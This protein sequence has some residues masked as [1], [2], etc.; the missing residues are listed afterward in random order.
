MTRKYF[1]TDGARGVVGGAIIN[2]IWMEKLGWAVGSTIKAKCAEKPLILIGEDSRESGKSL[3]LALEKGL[4]SA[5]A[6]VLLLGV[7]STPAIAYLTKHLKADAALVISASHNPYTDNGIKVIGN[8][9]FKFPDEWELSIEKKMDEHTAS[10]E[11]KSDGQVK[12]F[13]NAVADYIAHCK[14]LFPTLLSQYKI[15]IDCA[16][17]ATSFTAPTLFCELGA[18]VTAIHANPN[19]KNIN[20]HCGA[21]NVTSL[22]EKVLSEKADCGIAFDGDGDRLMM[23]DQRGEVVDGDEILGIITLHDPSCKA[24][25]GTLM[26]NLGLE[27]ALASHHIQFERV[28]V[29]DR[30]VLEQLRK[31]GWHLG[32]E[33]SGHI[34]NLHYGTT[35]DGIITA[36]QVLRIMHDT[37]NSLHVL[38]K[39]IQKRPQI[40]INVP[41]QNPHSFANIP[42]IAAALKEAEKKLGDAGRV[43][44]RASGTESCVRVMVE[45]DSESQARAVAEALAEVVKNSY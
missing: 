28:A 7:L 5:G 19:G 6:D 33:G 24:V 20:D 8:D 42:D 38:K 39:L 11:K 13:D 32:G 41:V 37:K 16:N 15:V 10:H 12:H 14:S 45:A 27:K 17:G 18:K 30:Y 31:N 23:V 1:G 3:S 26:S 2:P 21:T 35:G 43:L 44:L 40:L 9:G 29:G 25:V 22:R 36:L 34:I 4:T